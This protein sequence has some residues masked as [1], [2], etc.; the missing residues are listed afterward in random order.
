VKSTVR[1]KLTFVPGATATAGNGV[2][3]SRP[4][5]ADTAGA[6]APR[7]RVE[8]T[9]AVVTGPD[10]AKLLRKMSLLDAN[11]VRVPGW[12]SRES[13]KVCVSPATRFPSI[14]DCDS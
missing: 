7:T 2:V 11:C 4:S 3:T 14:D 6:N 8:M 1:S 9:S 10:R 5:S 13:A 12:A